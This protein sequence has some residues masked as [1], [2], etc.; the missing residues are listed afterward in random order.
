MQSLENRISSLLTTVCHNIVHKQRYCCQHKNTHV[1]RD[2]D[3]TYAVNSLGSLYQNPRLESVGGF[4]TSD[5][6]PLTVF[7]VFS[8]GSAMSPGGLT[9]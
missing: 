7:E 8:R 6:T 2:V 1:I 9:P 4:T 3:K 5:A